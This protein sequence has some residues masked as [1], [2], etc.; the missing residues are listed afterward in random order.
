MNLGKPYI[1]ELK[2][3]QNSSRES[4]AAPDRQFLKK[5]YR[6]RKSQCSVSLQ[7]Q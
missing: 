7:G 5:E 1:V 6:D 2:N 3:N 4:L